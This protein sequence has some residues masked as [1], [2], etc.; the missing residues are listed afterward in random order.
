MTFEFF[1][2]FLTSRLHHRTEFGVH[3]FGHFK[4]VFLHD[5][6]RAALAGL[7]VDA[8]NRLVLAPDIGRVNRQIGN[9]PM[10]G[11]RFVHIGFSLVDCVLV[12]TRKCGKDQFARIRLARADLHFG[13]ALIHFADFVDVREIQF[14]VHILGIHIQC[15]RDNI[16]IARALAVAKQRALNAVSARK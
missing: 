10:V 4:A 2:L 13:G 1:A 11:V 16:H 9:F 3:G 15:Q 5:E 12:R 14:A 6:R 8:D 7:A